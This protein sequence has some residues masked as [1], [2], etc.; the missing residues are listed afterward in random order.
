MALFCH[1]ALC[2]WSLSTHSSAALVHGPA[3]SGEMSLWARPSPSTCPPPRWLFPVPHASLCTPR[4]HS[5]SAPLPGLLDALGL[6]VCWL[7]LL[8]LCRQQPLL[9]EAFLTLFGLLPAPHGAAGKLG[10]LRWCIVI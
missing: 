4:A 7:W 2:W 5:A 6:V 8:P 9:Q 3:L 10:A 1:R